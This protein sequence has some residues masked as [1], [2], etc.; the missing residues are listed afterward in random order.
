MLDAELQVLA[1]ECARSG[2]SELLASMLKAG[3]PVNLSDARENS[4]LMLA[5]YHGWEETV[6]Q[7]LGFGLFVAIHHFLPR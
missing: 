4:L 2:E 3:M 5:A 7:L 6:R 1:L